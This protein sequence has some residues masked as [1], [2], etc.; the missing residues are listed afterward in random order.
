MIGRGAPSDLANIYK[1]D[2]IEARKWIKA[3][4]KKGA[5][6]LGDSSDSNEHDLGEIKPA[7]EDV[8]GYVTTGDVSL[9]RGEGFAIGAI[10]LVQYLALRKQAQRLSQSSVLVKIRNRD[11]TMCRAAYLELL[12]G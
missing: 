12:D 10:P 6:K 2:D 3:F 1:M 8:V 7:Q 4:S 9:T 11:T 5:A